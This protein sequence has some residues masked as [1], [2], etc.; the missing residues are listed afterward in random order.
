MNR[1]ILRLAIPNIVANVSI[2]LLGMVDL[3]LMGH[4][5]SEIYIG[6]VALGTVIFNFIYWGFSFLRMSTSGFTAQ[7]YGKEDHEEETA[8]FYRSLI[9]SILT[10]LLI[11]ILQK[12]VVWLSFLFINGSNEVET[13]ARS[14]FSIRIWA[15]P[16]TL[17]LYAISGWLLGMQ[18]ARYPMIIAILVNVF[19][20]AMSIFFIKVFHMKSEGVAL[21]TLCA[22]YIGIISAIVLMM[23]RYRH[24]P[25][26]F[27]WK[28]IADIQKLSAFFRVNTDIFIRTFCVIIVFA[29][30]TSKSASANDSILA[31]NSMLL[32]FLLLFSFFIDGFAFAGE[33]LI[34]KYIGRNDLQALKKVIRLLLAWGAGL[35]LFYSV[36]YFF[37]SGIILHILTNSHELISQS[38]PYLLWVVLIP[39]A[40][41]ATFIWDG[42][43][44]GATASKAMRNT[45]LAATFLVFTPTYFFLNKTIG[46]HSLWLA[47]SLFML[48]RGVFQTIIYKKTLLHGKYNHIFYDRTQKPVLKKTHDNNIKI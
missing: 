6:A 26:R 20:I 39:F 7:A 3:S 21:G 2:P 24:L 30:F 8:L 13:L 41:F 34:G 9:V 11:I 38:A 16:A 31:V 35:A 19:N 5:G 48:S 47:M 43:Y 14:Y 32:Q 10:G 15:A 29:F 1:K 44:I 18:N 22:Q 40:S 23:K 17:G 46:N 36:I 37:G 33:A 12:P 42:I 27:N 25:G 28:H 4:L 45:M